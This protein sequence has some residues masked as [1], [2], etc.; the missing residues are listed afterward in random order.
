MLDDSFQSVRRYV[1]QPE[2][3]T[4]LIKMKVIWILCRK[5]RCWHSAENE[6]NVQSQR[7]LRL[8]IFLLL[9]CQTAA[10]TLKTHSTG[11]WQD[12]TR[13]V[14]I[15]ICY[16]SNLLIIRL[17]CFAIFYYYNFVML[18]AHWCDTAMISLC[19]L[20]YYSLLI[21]RSSKGADTVTTKPANSLVL[22]CFEFRAKI[23]EW[24]W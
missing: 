7:G 1:L 13:S 9:S 16:I 4:F 2:I 19:K 14:F 20:F 21:C 18:D 11:A 15:Y 12:M 8:S 6:L 17:G 3:S 5:T 24:S 10:S 23:Q 22:W